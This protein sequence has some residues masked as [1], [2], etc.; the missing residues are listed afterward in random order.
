MGVSQ[1]HE[2]IQARRREA[3][4]D[5]FLREMRLRIG[6]ESVVSELVRGY[7]ARRARYRGQRKNMLQ[8]TFIAAAANLKRLA[9]ALLPNLSSYHPFHHLRFSTKSFSTALH[10]FQIKSHMFLLLKRGNGFQPVTLHDFILLFCTF[11]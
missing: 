9:L 5:A 1:H 7:G 11:V 6:I 4:T 3:R 2:L 10:N 8:I